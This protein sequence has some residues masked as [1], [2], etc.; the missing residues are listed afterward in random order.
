[1]VGEMV[2]NHTDGL[3][4]ST[5]ANFT[6]LRNVHSAFQS[7]A[8]VHTCLLPMVRIVA[9]LLPMVCTKTSIDAI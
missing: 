6:S 4:T 8:M 2:G 5:I 7:Y 3:L 1:M 9:Y